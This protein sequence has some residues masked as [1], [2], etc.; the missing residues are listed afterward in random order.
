MSPKNCQSDCEAAIHKRT[1]SSFDNLRLILQ[2]I[3]AEQKKAL[4]HCFPVTSVSQQ[5]CRI[6]LPW[7]QTVLIGLRVFWR[8]NCT[9]F[10][11]FSR[12]QIPVLEWR[13]FPNSYFLFVNVNN[14]VTSSHQLVTKPLALSTCLLI[15]RENWKLANICRA[16]LNFASRIHYN[17]ILT[18]L[19]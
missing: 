9:W 12:F 15:S 18:I 8:I 16:V 1:Q 11:L 13:L 3:V 5:D 19:Y 2:T 7:N 4:I 14:R 10:S 6:S 17:Y